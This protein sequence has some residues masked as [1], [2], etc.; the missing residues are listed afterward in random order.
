M[1]LSD[2][3]ENIAKKGEIAH[4]EN[5]FFC[6]NVFKRYLLLIRQNEYLWSK[7]LTLSQAKLDKNGRKLSK[8]VENT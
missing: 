3:V 5:F 8:W 1:Q 7:G 2:R 4:Y 6:N